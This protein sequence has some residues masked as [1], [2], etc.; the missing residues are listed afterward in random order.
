M[1]TRM[2]AAA[3]AAALVIAI[4]PASTALAA[5]ARVKKSTASGHAPAKWDLPKPKATSHADVAPPSAGGNG[6]G[7]NGIS[8]AAFDNGDLVVVLGTSTG[9]A[10]VFDR[11]RYTGLSSYA[12]ISAN[13]TPKSGVQMEQCAKYR[14]YPEAYGLWVPGVDWLG[15]SVRDFCR[16]QLGKPYNISASKTDDSKWYCSK[17]G[18]AG[19]KRIASR[20]LDA[21]GG[22]WVWPVDLVNS[23]YT[24]AFGHWL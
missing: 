20:D 4:A 16:R 8:F 11:S 9:H 17:L 15:T 22:Y 19:W 6:D 5:E 14:S 1:N 7:Y 18:W 13:I 12:V 3:V 24:A 23:R 21:D 10:G 2:I